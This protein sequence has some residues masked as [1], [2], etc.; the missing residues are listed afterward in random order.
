MI[1]RA[2]SRGERPRTSAKPCSVTNKLS[3]VSGEFDLWE[4]GSPT[5]CRARFGRCGKPSG[6][7]KRYR[8]YRS[9]WDARTVRKVLISSILTAQLSGRYLTGVCIIEILA[10]RKK[11]ADPPRPFSILLPLTQVELAWP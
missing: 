2:R 8:S 10:L 11:S 7:C 3:E 4:I 9:W 1:M 6:Q 5:Q